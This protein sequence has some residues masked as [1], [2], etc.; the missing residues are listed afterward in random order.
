ML[1][2]LYES[3]LFFNCIFSFSRLCGKKKTTNCASKN[4]VFKKRTWRLLVV[5]LYGR[6]KSRIFTILFRDK[7]RKYLFSRQCTWNRASG[8]F[9]LLHDILPFLYDIMS[10]GFFFFSYDLITN[11]MRIKCR[12]NARLNAI[13]KTKI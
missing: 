4:R 8:V 12:A 1:R 10:R 9:F 6:E 7:S 5:V 2:Y 3:L 11:K 13:F